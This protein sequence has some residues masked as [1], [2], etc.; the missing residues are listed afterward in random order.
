LSVWTPQPLINIVYDS[1][2]KL[3]KNGE[4]PV[5]ESELIGDLKRRG[6]SISR[7]DLAKV[8]MTLE[9]LGY[10]ATQPSKKELLISVLRS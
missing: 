9:I 10:I 1:L 4:I 3:S 2:V 6:E 8:L 5:S 7:R